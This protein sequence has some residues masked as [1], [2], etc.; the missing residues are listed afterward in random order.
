MGSCCSRDQS[1]SIELGQNVQ[2]AH[3][4]TDPHG[5]DSI[6]SENRKQV[7]PLGMAA[8]PDSFVFTGKLAVA[9]YT[10]RTTSESLLSFQEGDRLVIIDDSD[11]DWFYARH[12]TYKTEG[13]APKNYF[14]VD[15]NAADKDWFFGAVTRHDAERLLLQSD[16]PEGTFLV[17]NSHLLG[18]Y[19]L[20]LRH[21]SIERGV[22]VK[23]YKIRTLDA[24]GF[25]LN[26]KAIFDSLQQLVAYFSANANGLCCQLTYV[27]PKPSPVMPGLSPNI[28]DKWEVPYSSL[29]FVRSLGSGY[30]GEV[31]YG[32]LN[33]TFEVAIKCLKKGSLES[34]DFLREAAVM[35]KIRHSKIVSLYAVCTEKDPWCIIMEYMK[36][37]N[38][39]NYLR[40]GEGANLKLPSLVIMAAQ[41]ADG[42]VFL[43]N[44]Q[45]IHRDLAA[46]NILVGE[47]NVVKLGDFGL[48]RMMEEST[49]VASGGKV[50]VKW[51]APEAYIKCLF[52]IKSDVWSFG[53]VLYE[54]F[55]HGSS[56]YQGLTGKQVIDLIIEHNYR[57]PKP[58]DP[59]CSDAV[60][61]IMLQ[62]WLIQPE[63][64]PTFDFLYHFFT[65]Y[66]VIS[67]PQYIDS[68][69]VIS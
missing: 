31:W 63:K 61:D 9:M 49:Y 69:D 62:C 53:I 60:Y 26:H 48:A 12:L 17:R 51:T 34:D 44:N 18:A 5:G 45:M 43:E 32:F 40:N 55:T 24:G 19:A 35:K 25:F 14:S 29:K 20:S 4:K 46:R 59:E 41:I 66:S 39:L 38:L 64:R 56:P 57:M 1:V 21:Y 50:P 30:F 22:V 23:H 42:M 67:E 10:L 52:S 2:N 27:C 16:Y 68:D 58:N 7:A 11:P 37:G 36:N 54:L 8:E 13:Y 15:E 28:R 6:L 65:D 33:G 47:N 3:R